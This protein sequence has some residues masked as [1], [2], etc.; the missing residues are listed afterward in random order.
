MNVPLGSD[1]PHRFTRV[2]MR[3]RVRDSDGGQHALNIDDDALV[4]ALK[5]SIE[6]C[7]GIPAAAQQLLTGFPPKQLD[8]ADDESCASCVQ[9]GE[10]IQVRRV[11]SAAAVSTPHD[12]APISTYDAMSSMDE[13]EALARALALSM[14]DDE[15][16]STAA[17]SSGEA[18][19]DRAHVVRRVIAS[20]N[21]C[22]FNAVGYC[23]KRSLSEAPALRRAV[24]DAVNAEPETFN[25]AFLGKSPR[26]YTEWISKPKSWG[27]QVELFILSS[28]YGVEIAAYDIQTERCDVYGQ[29]KGYDSR[30]M[31]LYDGLHY[32]ALVLNPSPLGSDD[33]KDITRVS[34]SDASRLDGVD[35][36]ARAFVKGQHDA[37]SF[38]DTANFSLRCLVCQCGLK[39]QKEAV[40]HAK[41]TGHTNFGEY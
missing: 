41:S 29:D 30:I 21:S 7:T 19:V 9:S 3:L 37:R 11:T 20:D 36:K 25:D 1:T 26:E 34:T 5:A 31:V 18:S 22:L 40:E 28:F 33:S 24:V 2:I 12:T 15:H 4:A 35:A 17:P 38:T 39:G 32:D 14:N 6:A 13:D 27:G 16:A 8:V 23:V 10:T